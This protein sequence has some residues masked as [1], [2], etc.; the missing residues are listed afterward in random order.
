EQAIDAGGSAAAKEQRPEDERYSIGNSIAY[1]F[2]HVLTMYAGLMA[3]PLIIGQATDLTT[4]EI[5]IL[6]TA[7]FFMSGAATLLQTLGVKYIGSQLPIVQGVSF[8]SVATMVAI[9]TAGGGIT[10]IFGAVLV[11]AAIG[12]AISPFFSRLIRFFPPVVT[13]SVI[14]TIGFSLVPVAVTWSMGG[15]GASDFGSVS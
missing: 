3:V 2:Q 14:T 10:T 12:F 1:G 8:A 7:T 15:F 11:A 13:G 6:L 5:G 4:T 9:A